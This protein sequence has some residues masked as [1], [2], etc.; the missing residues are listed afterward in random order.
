MSEEEDSGYLATQTLAGTRIKSNLR[1]LGASI[2]VVTRQ[3]LEDTNVTRAS[4]LLIYTVGTETAGT[5][6][7]YPATDNG[8]RGD[9]DTSTTSVHGSNRFRA[10]DT[11]DYARDYFGT[12]IPFDSYN[13]ARVELN[14]GANAILFGLGSPA[15]ILNYNLVQP[16]FQNKGEV[17][18]RVDEHGSFRTSLDLDRELIEDTLAVR[19]AVLSDNTKYKQEPAYEHQDRIFGALTWNITK[20]LTF[21][22]NLEHGTMN[23]NRPRPIAPSEA[24]S[25]WVLLGNPIYDLTAQTTATNRFASLPGLVDKPIKDG[26]VPWTFPAGR[27]IELTDGVVYDNSRYNGTNRVLWQNA[28]MWQGTLSAT[29]SG[30]NV[31]NPDGS[32]YSMDSHNLPSHPDRSANHPLDFDGDGGERLWF[33]TTDTFREPVWGAGIEPTSLMDR[34]SFDFVNN[35]L[36]GDSSFQNSDFTAANTGLSLVSDDNTMGLDVSFDWQETSRDHFDG[37]G[38]G[39]FGH[40]TPILID[41]NPFFGRD[42]GEAFPRMKTL[43]RA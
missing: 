9:F 13:L 30:P 27:T 20:N 41:V 12:S 42:C 17:Q 36:A 29:Y 23:A 1:D 19:I 40:G 35:M 11:P 15:G 43:P 8:V 6:G 14:R 5:E 10:L 4:E 31:Q 32:I 38:V 33:W 34:R 7:N 37:V 28:S 16:T 21:R 18:F 24:F 22:G 3:F 25:P 2:S 26:G 39:A